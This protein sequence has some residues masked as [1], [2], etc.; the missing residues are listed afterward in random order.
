LFG[1]QMALWKKVY[2]GAAAAATVFLVISLF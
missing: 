1:R 2:F